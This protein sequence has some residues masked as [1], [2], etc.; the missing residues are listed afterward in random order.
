MCTRVKHDKYV[1]L[2]M[3][4]WRDLYIPLTGAIYWTGE[5]L[6]GLGEQACDLS[7]GH[8][9][10]RQA[11][12]LYFSNELLVQYLSLFANTIGF[13]NCTCFLFFRR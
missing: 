3:H 13:R 10:V 8:M 6:L 1:S 11:T 5:D 12:Y 4:I 9:K 7:A 2:L